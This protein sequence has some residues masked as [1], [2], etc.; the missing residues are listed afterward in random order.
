MLSFTV[1]GFTSYR[2]FM[3]QTCFILLEIQKKTLPLILVQ[4]WSTGNISSDAQGI[5]CSGRLVKHN[6]AVTPIK[7]FHVALFELHRLLILC[8]WILKCDASGFIIAQIGMENPHYT[9]A[10]NI[11][12][13]THWKKRI[14]TKQKT[15]VSRSLIF[16]IANKYNLIKKVYQQQDHLNSGKCVLVS[17]FFFLK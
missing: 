6:T 13:S 3:T 2:R 16:C 12:L 9:S 14:L 11:F 7:H 15:L 10:R 17:M 1:V 4:Q 5:W 8:S